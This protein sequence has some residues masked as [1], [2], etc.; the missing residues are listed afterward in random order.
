MKR[1][2][3]IA[4]ALFALISLS[5]AA[6]RYWWMTRRALIR[7]KLMKPPANLL[8]NAD[9]SQ[10]TNPNIPDYWGT[11]A[12]A[13]LEDFSSVLQIEKS[14]PLKNVRV[15]RLHNPQPNLEMSLQSCGT[16]LPKPK[17]YTFSIYLRSEVEQFRAALSIG[18]GK[19]N[20]VVVSD[21]WQRYEIV[22]TPGV[23]EELHF[24]FQVHVSLQ[25]E[26][27]LWLAAPQ[28]EEGEQAT[29]FVT[30]LM[31]DHPLAVFPTPKTDE[32]LKIQAQELMAETQSMQVDAATQ[33]VSIN[34][35]HRSL[36]KDG[37][38][39]MAFGIAI[40]EPKEWQFEDI[41]RQGFNTVA[42]F[43]PALKE[44]KEA[45]K[46]IDSTLAQLDAAQGK[47]LQVIPLVT[48]ERGTNLRQMIHEKI[49]FME[50][51]K[52]HPAILCWWILDE[53]TQ[54]LA[55]NPEKDGF[56]FYQAAKAADPS[57]PS[58]INENVWREGDWLTGFM[59]STDIISVDLYPIGQYQN[60]LRA[61]ADRVSAMNREGLLARK[62]SAF[63]LQLYGYYDAPREPTS[64]E[65][66]AMT[67]LVFIRG[68]RLIFYWMYK[69]MNQVLWE[70][71]KPLFEE[72]KQISEVVMQDHSRWHSVGTVQLQIHYALWEA[73]EKFYLIACNISSESIQAQFNFEQLAG[74][75]FAESQ[76]WYGDQVKS[77]TGKS[78]EIE[79]SPYG[80]QVMMLW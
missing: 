70:S 50:A 65:Q 27:N 48:H 6:W 60:P 80:R 45:K 12:A 35:L 56:E 73:G 34:R 75:S 59:Q 52:N 2:H 38:P 9:F 54:R 22:Y 46:S 16:F 76:S 58:F 61:V 23:K 57:R 55:Y 41:A 77:F 69:P 43:L 21:H 36:M 51:F 67:Y 4:L 20:P 19:K 8:R 37:K 10:S 63:W 29:S 44:A 40:S 24:G 47:G 13:A 28:L 53:P 62:P 18:W 49:R 17:P 31:D 7:L 71:L 3:F 66:R 15:L 14:A 26:G 68:V 33:A 25:Q 5:I 79:F 78:V 30:A 72:L 42:L 11:A 74:K 64:D 1:R 39:F 32:F